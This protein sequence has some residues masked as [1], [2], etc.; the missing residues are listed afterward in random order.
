VRGILAAVL[1]G[2]TLVVL[3]GTDGDCEALRDHPSAHDYHLEC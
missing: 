1:T 2:V 3:L